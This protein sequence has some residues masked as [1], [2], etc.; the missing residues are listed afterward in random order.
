MSK[1]SGTIRQNN[2]SVTTVNSSIQVKPSGVKARVKNPQQAKDDTS[3]PLSSS[4][5]KR[6][7][8]VKE[9]I[10]TV[11]ANVPS[12]RPERKTHHSSK[13]C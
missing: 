5:Y 10:N 1:T 7:S 2:P 8:N 11:S 3:T 4:S 13:F 6:Q 9:L 12:Q